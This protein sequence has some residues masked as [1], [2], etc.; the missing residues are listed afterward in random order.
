M[1]TWEFFLDNLRAYNTIFAFT[2]IGGQ[3]D[4]N[5]NNGAGPYVSRISGHHHHKI[6]S[7]LPQVVQQP[8]FAQLY[9]YDTQNELSNRIQ[10]I[11]M[12]ENSHQLETSFY[13]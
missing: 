4:N 3:V 13:C 12:H 9:I 2:S 1:Q 11:S 8:K 6:G 10:A 5:I 7:L